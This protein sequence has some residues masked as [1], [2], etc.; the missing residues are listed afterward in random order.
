MSE[1]KNN[2]T[3]KAQANNLENSGTNSESSPS[4]D[5]FE[6]LF[7]DGNQDE[8]QV[9]SQ[10]EFDDQHALEKAKQQV[11]NDVIKT[12]VGEIYPD[13]QGRYSVDERET[14]FNEIQS[15][16]EI[17]Y[18]EAQRALFRR[19]NEDKKMDAWRWSQ[20]YKDL[21]GGPQDG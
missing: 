8:E 7:C 6:T 17:R 19:L 3:K 20:F 10:Y 15:A 5:I 11:D 12:F 16:E 21:V 2:E 14:I 13:E 9:L 4:P 1:R 18:L